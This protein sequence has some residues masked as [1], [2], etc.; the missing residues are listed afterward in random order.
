MMNRLYFCG[1]IGTI[2]NKYSLY[3]T[4]KT[5]KYPGNPKVHSGDAF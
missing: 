5:I 1:Y 2:P 3:D 4:F